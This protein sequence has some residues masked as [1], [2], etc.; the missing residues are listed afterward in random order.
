MR[1]SYEQYRDN[2]GNLV[3]IRGIDDALVVQRK[4]EDGTLTYHDIDTGERLDVAEDGLIPFYQWKGQYQEGI[5]VTIANILK[6]AIESEDPPITALKNA[7][8]QYETNEYTR[9][10]FYTNKMQFLHDITIMTLISGIAV[11][12]LTGLLDDLF[13]EN[14]DIPGALQDASRILVKSLDNSSMDAN[15]VN[16]FWSFFG[17]WT[18]F[19]V[20]YMGRTVS[21][22]WGTISGNKNAFDA[23]CSQFS[24]LNQIKNTVSELWED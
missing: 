7:I 14:E 9:D 20:T 1:G 5:V 19:T 10:V 12:F 3:F 4:A 13:K 18:P 15:I 17:N 16:T 23:A 24:G 8:R 11:S 21:N 2:D 22:V 6:M